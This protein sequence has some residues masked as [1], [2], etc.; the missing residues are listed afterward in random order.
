[1]CMYAYIYDTYYGYACMCMCICVHHMH[2]NAC[3][4]NIYHCVLLPPPL[5]RY[6]VQSQRSMNSLR[7]SDAMKICLVPTL[8]IAG[9]TDDLLKVLTYTHSYIYIHMCVCVCV[10]VYIYSVFQLAH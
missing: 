2:M 4:Q 8:V 10:C 5:D 9:A 1:M 6:W 7:L 3:T